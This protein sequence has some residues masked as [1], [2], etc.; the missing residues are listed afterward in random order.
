[1]DKTLLVYTTFVQN[2][3]ATA[4]GIGGLQMQTMSQLWYYMKQN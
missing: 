4:E 3:N 2:L 1:M